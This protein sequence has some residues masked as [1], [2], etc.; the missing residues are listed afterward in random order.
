MSLIRTFQQTHRHYR[1]DVH[2]VIDIDGARAFGYPLIAE[3]GRVW[4]PAPADETRDLPLCLDCEAA[5]APRVDLRA[6]RPHYLYRCYDAAGRLIYVGCS[7]SPVQRMDQHKA[8]SWWFDQVEK[9]RYTVFPGRD[10]AIDMERAAIATENPRWNIQG[11]DRALWSADDYRD[12]H[13]ALTTKGASE[14][15]I[16]KLRLEA[17]RRHNVDLANEV[18]A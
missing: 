1:D 11:R 7:V 8:S 17:F 9:F 13:F 16:E 12:F 14:K 2:N 3:C 15:R 18:S 10:K 4:I 5:N 6:T